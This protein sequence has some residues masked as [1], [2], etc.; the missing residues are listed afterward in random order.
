MIR[1]L[2][3]CVFSGVPKSSKELCGLF[4]EKTFNFEVHQLLFSI[5]KICLLN[6]CLKSWLNRYGGSKSTDWKYSELNFHSWIYTEAM[7]SDVIAPSPW[8]IFGCQNGKA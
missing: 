8:K 4:Q 3:Y 6:Q 5:Y 7:T 1:S 2:C